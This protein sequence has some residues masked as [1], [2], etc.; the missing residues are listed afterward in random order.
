MTDLTPSRRAENLRLIEKVS[1]GDQFVTTVIEVDWLCAAGRAVNDLPLYESALAEAER[2]RDQHAAVLHQ[3]DAEIS[4]LRENFSAFLD[5]DVA[6]E[7]ARL[8]STLTEREAQLAEALRLVDECQ[9]HRYFNRGEELYLAL[10]KLA[11][12]SGK[13]G[14]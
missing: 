10:V 9:S 5:L 8:R 7:I 13:A 14:E 1:Q 4:R 11:T 2:E 6:K 12:N 3:Q